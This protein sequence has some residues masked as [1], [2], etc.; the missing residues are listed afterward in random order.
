M[1]KMACK[2]RAKKSQRFKFIIKTFTIK[3]L[4]V[5]FKKRRKWNLTETKPI[6][7]GNRIFLIDGFDMGFQERTGTYVICDEQITLVESCASPSVPHII[8][9]LET[10]E[11][12]LDEIKYII[13]THVHLDHAGGAGLLMQKC[14]NAKLVVHPRGARHMIDPSRLIQGA[15]AVYGPIFDKL[16][17]PIL[18]IPEERVIVKHDGETLAIGS[19][20]ELTFYDTPGHANHHFS[21]YDPKSN[22]IFVGDT[23]GVKNK[24]IEEYGFTFYLPATSPNQFDPD[25]TMESL[26]RIRN[27]G[28]DR[29]YFGHFGMAEDVD[30][31]YK[32]IEHWL[33]IY[34]KTGE[35]VYRE[36]KNANELKKRLLDKISAVLDEHSIPKNHIAYQI[37]QM[38]LQ[39]FSMGIIDYFSKKEKSEAK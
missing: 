8:K 18:P 28:V 20:C 32:Q 24:H 15:K 6:D 36:G 29:I 26:Q 23:L 30:E 2:Y 14:P 1:M 17:D 35:E 27:L 22:G 38:D 37:I 13:V 31:V 21:I 25:K 7:L 19:D 12:P 4:Q 10:L 33:P 39:I 9:G 16:F 34:V 5:F 3:V 11:I